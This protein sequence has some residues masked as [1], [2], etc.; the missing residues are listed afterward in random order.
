M[1]V[2][3]AAAQLCLT[4]PALMTRRDELFP[5]ARQVV[6]NSG[7]QYS[8]GHS[9][10]QFCQSGFPSKMFGTNIKIDQSGNTTFVSEEG[11]SSRDSSGDL[12]V[13]GGG[14]GDPDVDPENVVGTTPSSSSTA[15]GPPPRRKRK[16]RNSKNFGSSNS[17]SSTKAANMK[18]SR[19]VQVFHLISNLKNLI[20][21]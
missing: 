9:R 3:E 1:S 15:I 19:L 21:I 13:G 6:R 7:Y 16:R 8:K 17:L 20:E 18:V 5:L 10:S 4:M 12:D 2:N 11:S 14:S